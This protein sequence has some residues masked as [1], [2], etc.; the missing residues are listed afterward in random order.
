MF[1]LTDYGHILDEMVFLFFLD[2]THSFHLW[3]DI[4]THIIHLPSHSR[5]VAGPYAESK[6]K[7]GSVATPK[8]ALLLPKIRIGAH[9]N[10]RRR[11]NYLVLSFF[12]RT[13]TMLFTLDSCG[14]RLW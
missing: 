12:Y 11:G 3:I 8:K 13:R 6:Q 10:K 7:G 1:A 2:D 5:R 14:A 9:M 4:H